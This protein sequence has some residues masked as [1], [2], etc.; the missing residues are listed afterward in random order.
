MSKLRVAFMGSPPFAVPSLH[1]AARVCTLARV[2]S[3]PDRPAGRGRKLVAPAVKTAALELGV[4]VSQP[5]RLRDGAVAKK[6]RALELDLL[7][8]AA[9]GRILPAAILEA[10]R[11]GCINVHASLLPRWRGAAPIQRSIL[12]GDDET[13]VAIMRMA[14]GLDTGPV[15]SMVRTP[16]D[17]LE[18]SGALFERLAELGAEAL[19]AFL[20][21]FPDVPPPTPQDDALATYAPMLE[22]HEGAVDWTRSARALVDHI[23]GMDPWPTAVTTRGEVSLKLFAARPSPRSHARAPGEVLGVDADGLHVACG[24]GAICVAEVQPAGKRR[25]EARAY[26]V[27]NPF[28]PGERLGP[29]T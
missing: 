23:R 2:Y 27:G 6:L 7:I 11:C 20:T 21:R 19:A 29:A 17:P 16:I 28:T 14:E 8:V 3:Q 25:M 9:Y 1:A 22:K 4:P 10:P 18:T 13:G 5:R 26:A 15:Y 12:A 24:A